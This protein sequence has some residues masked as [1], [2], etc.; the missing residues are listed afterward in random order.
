MS[1]DEGPRIYAKRIKTEHLHAQMRNHGLLQ[2]P[3]RGLE[4]A[5]TIALWF[6]VATNLLLHTKALIEMV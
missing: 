5:K 3:V 2:I 6:A 4:K 1:G